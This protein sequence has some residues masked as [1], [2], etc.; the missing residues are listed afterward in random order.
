MAYTIIGSERSPFVRAIRMFMHTN[1]IAFNFKILNFVDDENAAAEV[2]KETPIN[3]V[4]VLITEKGEKIFD[5]RVIF[6][7]LTAK[8]N[9]SKL[10]LNDENIVTS[11]YSCL[12][13]GVLLFLL[14]RA[15]IDID[16]DEFFFNRNRQ[17]IPANLEYIKPW[18]TTLTSADWKFPAMLLYSFIYWAQKRVGLKF[19]NH[20]ELEAF[21]KKFAQAPGVNETTWT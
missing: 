19:D 5:S 12:D 21:M 2:A 13:T 9:L 15:K 20:P 3:K 7:Y 1:E 4:P 14:K 11:I 16:Q 17:R 10:S 6:N 18:V 8:H